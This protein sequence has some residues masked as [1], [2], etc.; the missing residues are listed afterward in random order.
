VILLLA[1]IGRLG[2]SAHPARRVRACSVRA[3]KRGRQAP[4]YIGFVLR[5]PDHQP[6]LVDGSG[7]ELV[8]YMLDLAAGEG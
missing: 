8:T 2:G 5:M 6:N 4:A 3:G 1:V 7:C